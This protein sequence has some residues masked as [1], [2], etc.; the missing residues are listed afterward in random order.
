MVVSNFAHS[1][2]YVAD[3]IIMN[4]GHL[5]NKLLFDMQMRKRHPGQEAD[6]RA[7]TT[8]IFFYK[9]ILFYLVF[10]SFSLC[11]YPLNKTNARCYVM[12]SARPSLKEIR[13][14]G[15]ALGSSSHLQCFLGC[16]RTWLESKARL[17]S[18]E[19]GSQL[20]LTSKGAMSPSKG[21]IWLWK[22]TVFC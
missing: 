11:L 1:W 6:R 3:I 8:K 4:A 2:Y 16:W 15:S 21:G 12:R 7:S 10:L 19:M 18:V 5:I 17:M 14:R 22:S 9:C 13:G 20:Q